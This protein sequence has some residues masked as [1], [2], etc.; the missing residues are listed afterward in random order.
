MPR[1]PLLTVLP[2]SLS[3]LACSAALAPPPFTP[4]EAG[5]PP[6]TE[7][8]TAHFVL[9]TD[10]AASEARAM[11]AEFE[12]MYAMFEDVAFPF[13][14]RLTGRTGLLIFRDENEYN[15]VAP[16]NTSGFYLRRSDD[17]DESLPSVFLFGDLTNETRLRFQ[18]ELTHKFVHF[19]YPAAPTWLNE[20]L[21]QY[22]STMVVEDGKVVLGRPMPD[23]RFRPGLSWRFR[24]TPM[25][26]TAFVPVGSAPS[27]ADLLASDRD[28][29]HSNPTDSEEAKIEESRRVA[30]NYAGAW[31]LV[32]LLR[33]GPA[34]YPRQ[35]E[36][37]MGRLAAGKPPDI[38]WN[39][40]FPAAS[41]ETI[42][43]DY[44]ASLLR[45]ETPPS[46]DYTPRQAPI[47]TERAMAADEVHLLLAAIR[48]SQGTAGQAMARADIDAAE[49]LSKGS[50]DVKLWRARLAILEGRLGEAEEDLKSA[51]AA[52]PTEEKYLIE[53]FNLYYSQSRRAPADEAL[54]ARVDALVP[55]LVKLAST[56][57]TLNRVAW[58]LGQRGKIDEALPLALRAVNAS[59][60]CYQCLDTLASLMFRK[61]A[62]EKAIAA[63]SIALSVLPEGVTDR[64]M[65]GRLRTYRQVLAEAK[66][67]ARVPP[68]AN[69]S[70]PARAPTP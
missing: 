58:Y 10:L 17:G 15:K 16:H 29:F 70:Q 56:A 36:V 23:L 19:Y 63:Q 43:R 57:S 26:S 60:S 51:V 34:P 39:E 45:P 1:T 49:R 30:A 22:F 31:A 37:F 2:L 18:H 67:A 3:S 4:P 14:E 69:T 12:Q 40:T 21:A 62:V 35:F 13:E 53:L 27:V 7:I 54:K 48:L 47:D 6:W 28:A 50:P 8:T 65:L 5:G 38:A 68:A 42:E 25:W 9:R 32:H 52:R 66:A 11:V 41:M 24:R 55:A 59:F 64:G 20:G 44:Q 33:D 61:G 46:R